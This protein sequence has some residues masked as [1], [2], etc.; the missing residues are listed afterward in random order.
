MEELTASHWD[1]ILSPSTVV[2]S[3]K[4]YED[5]DDS[6]DHESGEESAVPAANSND[7]NFEAEQL[8]QLRLDERSQT[9]AKL[10]EELAPESSESPSAGPGGSGIAAEEEKTAQSSDS[11]PSSTGPL[12]NDSSA[13]PIKYTETQNGEEG[14]TAKKKFKRPRKFSSLKNAKH[15]NADLGPLGSENAVKTANKSS[16]KEDILKESEA[17]LYNIEG[18]SSKTPQTAVL[19]SPEPDSV[20]NEGKKTPQVSKGNNLEITVS[21]PMKVGD[22]TN[23]H[24]IYTVTTKV[25]SE[26]VPFYRPEPYVVTRRYKDFRWIYHQLQN[27]HMGRIIPPPPSKQT[28]IGRFNESFIENRRLSLEKMLNKISELPLSS[29]EDFIMFLTSEDFV[30]ESKERER[31]SGSKASLQ[32]D[33]SL[34][35]SVDA[36]EQQGGG[37]ISSIFSISN[38]VEE[39]DE[40]F[41]EKRHYIETLESNLRNFYQAIEVIINQRMEM[42]TVV[43]QMNETIDELVELEISKNTSNVLLAFNDVQVKLRESLDRINLQDHLTLGFTIEEHL[44]TIGSIKYIFEQRNKIYSSYKNNETELNK[45]RQQLNKYR[46]KN[47]DK[48]GTVNFEVEKLTEKTDKF[49]TNFETISNVI[50][51]ELENFDMERIE[52][53]RNSVEI[54][55]ESSIESQ[56][57]SIELWETFYERQ[58]LYKY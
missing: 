38:K 49:K 33:L 26:S 18:T 32:N 55:I 1:D 54:Y 41:T 42:I 7:Y 35:N 39:P 3:Y 17:P 4:L 8:S 48:A 19:A 20:N 52:E 43:E 6:S 45:K 5:R 56:K 12:F 27:N 51:E 10:L 14:L 57:E 58:Q 29:D 13:S 34:D 47:N 31:I 22:I 15:L 25:K 46:L 2:D 9:K 11:K 28:Y 23:A 37:F 53:F 40:F 16:A 24:I 21:D 30:N 44:R 50:K 36:K